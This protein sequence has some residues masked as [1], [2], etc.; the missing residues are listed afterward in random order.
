MKAAL[1]RRGPDS[2][3]TKKV[4]LGLEGT[5]GTHL[6][7]CVAPDEEVDSGSSS[8]HSLDGHKFLANG[9]SEF[10]TVQ[11]F[12]EMY[13]FGSVLQLRGTK[14]VVQPLVDVSGNVLVY[15]GKIVLVCNGKIEFIALLWME[16][17]LSNAAGNKLWQIRSP[18]NCL[19]LED[20]LV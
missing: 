4:F 14:P 20:V 17:C 12:A 11:A 5:A 9:G 1:R 18:S 2:L 19:N 13:F 7:S 15:N 10:G 6:R 16:S 8:F 3:R